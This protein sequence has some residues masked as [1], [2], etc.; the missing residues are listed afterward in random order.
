MNNTFSIRPPPHFLQLSSWKKLYFTSGIC[1]YVNELQEKY[2]P[3]LRTFD[4]VV[5][6]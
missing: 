1:L 3:T 2:P 4:F 6:L 5:R